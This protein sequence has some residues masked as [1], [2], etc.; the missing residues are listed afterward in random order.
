MFHFENNI[1]FDRCILNYEHYSLLR[2][3]G[4]FSVTVMICRDGDDD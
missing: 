4:Y 2:D 3:G 1:F